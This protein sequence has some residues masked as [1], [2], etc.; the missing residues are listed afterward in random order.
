MNVSPRGNAESVVI[1]LVL[2]PF[3]LYQ[4]VSYTALIL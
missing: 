3:H 1:I 2:L 4:Q